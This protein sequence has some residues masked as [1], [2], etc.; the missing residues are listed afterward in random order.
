VATEVAVDHVLGPEAGQDV[1]ID[2]HDSAALIEGHAHGVELTLVPPGC[3]AHQQAAVRQEVHAGELL[4]EHDRVAKREDQDSGAEL[5]AFC[6]RSDRR[7]Q[8]Q[9]IDDRKVRTDAEED[10]IP[11]PQRVE[12]KLLHPH[13]V[14]HERL[15]V[16]QGGVGGEVACGDPESSCQAHNRSSILSVLRELAEATAHHGGTE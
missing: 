3:H 16:R 12:A 10:V 14:V 5:D 13:A 15:C 6:A 7:Q 1:E 11:H 9:G 2:V 8:R 4:R